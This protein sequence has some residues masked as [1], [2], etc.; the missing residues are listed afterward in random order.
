M[1][2]Y[3]SGEG[4]PI[5]ASKEFKEMVKALHSAGIEV[6]MPCIA[7]LGASSF[8]LFF[9]PIIF[10]VELIVKDRTILTI[11]LC[12]SFWTWFIIIPMKQMINTLTP[13]HF[14]A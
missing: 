10:L 3:A 1:S 4:D 14:V 7:F 12:R 13:P 5:K 2:R 9:L 8:I 11:F 6:A